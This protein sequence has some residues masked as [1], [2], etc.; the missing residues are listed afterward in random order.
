LFP[1]NASYYFCR[2]NIP[3]GLDAHEFK[4]Q[5]AKFQLMGEV[6][7]SVESAYKI[8]QGKAG[9]NDLIYIGGSTFVVAEV[10]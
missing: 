2:P 8:A 4:Q 3:R 9:K 7:D 1:K 5:C 6:Y 10:L